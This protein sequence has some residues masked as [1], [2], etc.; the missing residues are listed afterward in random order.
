MLFTI[1]Q[2]T[3]NINA[4]LIKCNIALKKL[5][6]DDWVFKWNVLKEMGIDKQL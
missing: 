4:Y 6:K 2:F 3:L 1:C 5:L